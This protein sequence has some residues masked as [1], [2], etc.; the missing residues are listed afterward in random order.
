MLAQRLIVSQVSKISIIKYIIEQCGYSNL[1]EFANCLFYTC[2]SSPP[3]LSSITSIHVIYGLL[4]QLMSN[5]VENVV[6]YVTYR[7]AR[8]KAME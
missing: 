5:V 7:W 1:N 6:P 2:E 4:L 3:F 8:Y